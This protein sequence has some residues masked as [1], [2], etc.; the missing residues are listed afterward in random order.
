MEINVVS[1]IDHL[2]DMNI[3]P[4][5]SKIVCIRRMSKTGEFW[6]T[7]SGGENK[8]MSPLMVMLMDLCK[9]K[10]IS[11]YHDILI[12]INKNIFLKYLFSL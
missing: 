6:Q 9:T 5:T 2:R 7:A 3:H 11:M 10:I 12:Q 4:L 8:G 1:L